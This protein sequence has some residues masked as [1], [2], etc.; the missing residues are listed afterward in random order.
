[1]ERG[2]LVRIWV[3][4]ILVRLKANKRI[5]SKKEAKI[6]ME[7]TFRECTLI[8]LEKLFNLVAL[9]DC[10]ALQEW[11]AGEADISEWEHQNLLF[12][13]R[14][15]NHNVHSWNEIELIQH[16]IGPI[17]TLVDFSGKQFNYFAE[18]EFRGQIGEVTLYGNPDG[19]IASGTREPEKPYFC[20]QEYKRHLDPKG[21]PAGQALAAMLAAQEL[22]EHQYPV[23]G[24]YVVG[25]VWRFML[26]QEREY[27]LSAAYSATGDGLFDIFR[28]LKIVKQFVIK[29]TETK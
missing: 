27:C 29:V 7:L 16:F 5:A 11:L 15:L 6:Y 24:C 18:R 14:I 20:F 10:P 13:R 26:L 22:N 19:M 3:A 9:D 23:Y 1:L 8:K 2:H 4:D 21:D 12:F 28:I 17:F 25:D